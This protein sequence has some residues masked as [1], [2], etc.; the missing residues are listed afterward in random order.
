LLGAPCI[1]HLTYLR[2]YL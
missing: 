2:T 1:N